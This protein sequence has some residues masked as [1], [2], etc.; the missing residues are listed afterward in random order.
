LN[1]IG[2]GAFSVVYTS[3]ILTILSS[4]N[5]TVLSTMSF[6]APTNTVQFASTSLTVSQF[7]QAIVDYLCGLTDAQV[8]LANLVSICSF[9]Y[10]GVLQSVNY[11]I[12]TSQSV[13]NINL[14]AAIC[15]IASRINSLTAVTCATLKA[16]F[17]DYP[18]VAFGVNDR[19]YGT[20]NGNCASITDQQ[21]ANMV[22]AAIGKYSDVKT[23]FCAINCNTAPSC[24]DVAN[25]NL[26]IVGTAIGVYGLTWA[27]S[28]LATQTVT[29]KYRQTG[30][31]TWFIAT[32][33][34]LIL[35]NGN[36]SGTSPYTISGLSSGTSYDVQIV[37]NCGGVG[38]LKSITTPSG[39]VYTANY[40][41]GNTLYL[42]CGEATTPLYSATPFGPG[43]TMYSDIGLTTPVTGYAY[44]TTAGQDI[45]NLNTGTGVVGTDTGSNCGTGTAGTYQ[46]GND[47]STICAASTTTLYT[48]G[49]FAVGLTLY[50]DSGLTN[51]QTGYSYVVSGGNIYTVNSGTGA[52]TGSAGISCNNYTLS[53]QYNFSFSSVTGTGVPYLP[54]TGTSGNVFGHQTGISGNLSITIAGSIVLPCKIDVIKNGSVIGCANITGAGNYIIACSCTASDNI[55]IAIDSGSC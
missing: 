27:T 28:T 4:A 2:I 49:A 40:Q 20:L 24:P 53:P 47:T 45:Y 11:P 23:N 50:T 14:G 19:I 18:G 21:I 22:I 30:T 7:L 35:P 36:I 38:F 29:V 13:I 37:N 41:I 34:L 3:G 32:N 16:I 46:L 8:Y 54:P 9:D 17:Q 31:L 33:A 1:G 52:I 5:S 44:I 48:N 10:N 39:S 42:L 15:N 51:P 25:I 12:G 6:G 26:G 55:T 43:V